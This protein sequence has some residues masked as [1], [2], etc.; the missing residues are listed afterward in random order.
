ML[1]ETEG[2]ATQA[3]TECPFVARK[4]RLIELQLPPRG[5]SSAPRLC[6]GRRHLNRAAVISGVRVS[7]CLTS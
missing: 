7:Q 6:R 5:S 2:R 4:S 1:C 3:I